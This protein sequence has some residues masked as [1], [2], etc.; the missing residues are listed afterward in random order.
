MRRLRTL[1]VVVAM[2]TAAGSAVLAP[3]PT[4]AATQPVKPHYVPPLTVTELP[5]D[6]PPGEPAGPTGFAPADTGCGPAAPDAVPDGEPI[7]VKIGFGPSFTVGEI[8]ASWWRTPPYGDGVWRLQLRGMLWVGSLAQRAYQDG[9]TQSLRALVD[10]VLAF[11]RQNPDPGTG[12]ATSTAN[13]NAWGWDEGT[14]LRRLG[15]EN[16]LYTLTKDQRL[17]AVMGADVNVQFGPRYYGPPRYMVHNHGVWADLTIVRAADLLGRTDWATRSTNRLLTNA[18]LPWTPVGTSI[19]QSSS[20]H[21]FNVTLWRQVV[22]MLS[23]HAVA[24]ASVARVNELVNKAD[25]VSPWLTEPDGRIV[26]L[27]D[28][29]ASAG[30]TRSRW[31]VRTFRDDRAGLVVGKWS[32]TDPATTYYTIR[33]GPPRT[34]HGQ[35]ERAGITWSTK[36]LRVLVGPGKAPFD[37]AGNYRS[38]GTSPAAHNVSTADRRGLD[39]KASVSVTASTIRGPA[40]SWSTQDRLFGLAHT[41]TY[42]IARD[43]RTLVVK[44]IYDGKAAFRQYWHLDPSWTHRYISR[45]GKRLRFASPG[46][47]LTITTTGVAA[48]LRAVTRPVAGWNFPDGNS[49]VA[50][51]EIQVKAAGTALTTFVLS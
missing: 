50:A 42:V 22:D 34:A 10:Q 18:P 24:P 8:P 33:Y 6:L 41:R 51:N 35:Q 48:V 17:A 30:F 2:A 3:S 26:V 21:L 16:C 19:E 20:Y 46:G 12:T 32:W 38:W 11:H 15:T 37:P 43:T 13:A 40:H 49:R 4:Q 9:Q 29:E 36:G 44:D 45:D 39:A 25:R 47:T 28:S 27:G 7:V 14:A 1:F 23:A 31:T 5:P